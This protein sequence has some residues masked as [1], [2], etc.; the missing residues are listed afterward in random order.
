MGFQT[1]RT[2]AFVNSQT[3]NFL[4]LFPNVCCKYMKFKNKDHLYYFGKLI[5]KHV[6]ISIL[7]DERLPISSIYFYLECTARAQFLVLVMG[8]G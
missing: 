1:D 8:L 4:F 5:Q 7:S 2:V 6:R 3:L